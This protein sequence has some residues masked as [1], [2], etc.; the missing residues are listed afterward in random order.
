MLTVQ[1]SQ[2]SY[3][4]KLRVTLE[5]SLKP[6]EMCLEANGLPHS[7]LS[8][9]TPLHAVTGGCSL[10]PMDMEEAWEDSSRAERRH[11]DPE[12]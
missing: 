7:R 10:V 3:S 1:K 9:S 4:A 8:C 2:P 5:I 6:V 12:G 11:L